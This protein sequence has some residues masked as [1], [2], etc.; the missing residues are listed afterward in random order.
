MQNLACTHKY[1]VIAGAYNTYTCVHTYIH[2]HIHT[3]TTHTQGLRLEEE[4]MLRLH[5]A[6]MRDGGLGAAI[7]QDLALVSWPGQGDSVSGRGRGKRCGVICEIEA[8][9]CYAKP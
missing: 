8:L 1:L 4:K 6:I 9:T 7:I 3:H 2:M 5:I